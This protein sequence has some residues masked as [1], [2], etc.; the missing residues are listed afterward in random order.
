MAAPFLWNKTVI[1]SEHEAVSDDFH[2]PHG[3]R[4]EE[5][6]AHTAGPEVFAP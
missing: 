1:S 2:Q 3:V 6:E 5:T 4:D